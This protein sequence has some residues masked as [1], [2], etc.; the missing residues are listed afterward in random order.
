MTTVIIRGTLVSI[1]HARMYRWLA[2]IT[3]SDPE[4]FVQIGSVNGADRI[5]SILSYSREVATAICRFAPFVRITNVNVAATATR[6]HS[7]IPEAIETSIKLNP[8]FVF[9]ECDRGNGAG[10]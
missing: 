2:M 6:P 8:R 7:R 4:P 3:V 1:C 9:K 10:Q 5:S